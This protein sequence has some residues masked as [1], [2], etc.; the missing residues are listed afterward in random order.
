MYLFFLTLIV[1][2]LFGLFGIFLFFEAVLGAKTSFTLMYTY[3]NVISMAVRDSGSGS[4]RSHVFPFLTLLLI[5]LNLGTS[6]S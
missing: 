3:K 6:L 4:E 1:Y 2:I 5:R